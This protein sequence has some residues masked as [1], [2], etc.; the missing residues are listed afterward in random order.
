MS[1]KEWKN[2]KNSLPGAPSRIDNSPRMIDIF[3]KLDRER[4]HVIFNPRKK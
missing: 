2:V 4:P 3:K 1:N